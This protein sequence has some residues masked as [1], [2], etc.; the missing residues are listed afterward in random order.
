MGTVPTVMEILTAQSVG[1][2]ARAMG[3]PPRVMGTLPTVMEI[4]ITQ[5][6]GDTAQSVG[7]SPIVME[8][9]SRMW[10]HHLEQWGSHPE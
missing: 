5:S 7:T 4:L 9:L 2:P 1:T 3:T 10:G 6:D 8:I